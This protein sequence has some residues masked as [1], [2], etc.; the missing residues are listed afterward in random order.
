MRFTWLVLVAIIGLASALV[1]GV[2]DFLGGVA[3]RRLR[4]LVAVELTFVV[5]TVIALVAVLV[6]QPVWSARDL[7]LGLGAGV[8]G[9]LATWAFYGCL[10]IG[11]MSVLSPV[12]AVLNAVLP[13]ILGFALGERLGAIGLLGVAAVV[14]AAAL[15]GV[16]RQ[17][18]GSRLSVRALLLAVG[19]G[20]GFAAYFALIHFTA[21]ESGLVPL[22]GDYLAGTLLI[23]IVLLVL[24][25]RHGAVEL[26]GLGRNRATGAAVLAGVLLAVANILLVVGLH[27]GDLAVMSVLSALYPASTVFLAFWFLRE[28][29]SAW[30]WIG[31]VLGIGGTAAIAAG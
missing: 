29:L 26:A 5:A 12:V 11:P 24:R 2:S 13:A 15:L 23:A 7:L 30:Q 6:E 21:P 14:I 1:Y 10:A 19:A 9:A 18:D 3:S 28:R 25:W 8:A 22:V 20:V 27:L 4:P 17:A 31:V 16:S